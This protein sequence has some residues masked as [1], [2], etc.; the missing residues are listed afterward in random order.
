MGEQK[1]LNQLMDARQTRDS[2]INKQNVLQTL[3]NED[4]NKEQN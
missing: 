4:L 2:I 1:R 3:I